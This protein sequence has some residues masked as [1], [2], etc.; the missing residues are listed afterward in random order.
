MLNIKDVCCKPRRGISWSMAAMLC[1]VVVVG[2]LHPRSM[3]LAMLTMKNLLH[4]F[5]LLWMHV[6]LSLWL[7]CSAWWP[8]VLP[9]L[10]LK[11]N[12]KSG[13][14]VLICHTRKSNSNVDYS[15]DP[16]ISL[17]FHSISFFQDALE[18]RLVYAI[19]TFSI[20]GLSLSWQGTSHAKENSSE[21]EN[22]IL[23]ITKD[24]AEA[25][26]LVFISFYFHWSFNCNI[27]WVSE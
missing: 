4:G 17:S 19:L 20:P 9:E 5:L 22:K 2:R 12:R 25:V 18:K 15:R 10:C 16:V 6:V 1:D 7:W 8:F 23:T 11:Q 13:I 26:L 3:S 14:P 24:H 21:V 27:L